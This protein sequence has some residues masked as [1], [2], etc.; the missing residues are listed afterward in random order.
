MTETYCLTDEPFVKKL[1]SPHD[2]IVKEL[3]VSHDTLEFIFED[4][5]TYHDGIKEMFP[6]KKSLTMRFHLTAPVMFVYREKRKRFSR[7]KYGLVDMDQEKLP[8]LCRKR[9][10][11]LKLY[12][13][14][15]SVFIELWSP[16]G[17]TLINATTDRVEYEWAEK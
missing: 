10:E 5:V 4:D 3:K 9:L 6:G 13:G 16:S 1:F 14:Y 15:Q 12:S 8:D 2:F 7:K 17:Q 11:F